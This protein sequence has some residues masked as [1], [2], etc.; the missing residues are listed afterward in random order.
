[1]H[2]DNAQAIGMSVQCMCVCMCV[3]SVEGS[4]P[5]SHY[6]Q[7]A[8]SP[9]PNHRTNNTF[10]TQL[11]SSPAVLATQ[12]SS[13]MTPMS[14]SARSLLAEFNKTDTPQQ[15]LKSTRKAAPTPRTL[16]FDASYEDVGFGERTPSGS[17]GEG[18]DQGSILSE[19]QSPT[20][21]SP[22]PPRMRM[23]LEAQAHGVFDG[24][25]E[26]EMLMPSF[27]VG[28]ETRS[29]PVVHAPLAQEV[30]TVHVANSLPYY[31][32]PMHVAA[33]RASRTLECS[34]HAVAC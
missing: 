13:Q 28:S 9:G 34:W 26:G 16:K 7:G 17:E 6:L 23:A 32:G 20:A 15:G 2:P 10:L 14:P 19:P 31:R 22:C 4:P 24:D 21:S 18:E 29:R 11:Y 1:M 33:Q 25:A 3:Q 12:L 27:S 30:S 5:S 8:P